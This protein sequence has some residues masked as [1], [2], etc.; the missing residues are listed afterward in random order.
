MFKDFPLPNHA[1]AFKAAEAAHCAGEQG[2]Y[3]EMHDRMFGDQRALE[4]PALKQSAAGLGLNAAAFN[5][6]L[7]SGKFADV[8]KEDM[9][10]GEKMGV[11]S[12]PTIYIN[13]R[14]YDRSQEIG[15][16]LTMELELLGEGKS[17][18]PPASVQPPPP[19]ASG[20]K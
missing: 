17:A 9:A 2:K 8:I 18:Q 13:G 4:V 14:E 19:A 11:N 5:Q 12:T 3:W 10:L 16:W 20:D 1:N 6:C 15:D 7:E